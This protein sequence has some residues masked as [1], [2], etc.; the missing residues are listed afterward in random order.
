MA[1]LAN[2]IVQNCMT[3]ANEPSLKS[4]TIVSMLCNNFGVRIINAPPLHRTS[5]GQVERFHSTWLELARCIKID[6]GIRSK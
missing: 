2:E 3:C 1:M 5:N 4:H 6:K